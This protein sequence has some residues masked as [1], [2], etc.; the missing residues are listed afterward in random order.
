MLE[1]TRQ[2]YF[3]EWLGAEQVSR[4]REVNNTMQHWA[5]TPSFHVDDS[6]VQEFQSLS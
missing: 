2:A 1:G 6:G 3:C 4:Y 5:S